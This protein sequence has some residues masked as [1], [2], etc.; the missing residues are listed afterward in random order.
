MS[1]NVPGNSVLA[2]G[3]LA[4]AAALAAYGLLLGWTG[5]AFI[6]LARAGLIAALV[7]WSYIMLR[8]YSVNARGSFEPIFSAEF[9]VLLVATVLLVLV[10]PRIR[11]DDSDFS[12][13]LAEGNG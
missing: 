8:V 3:W 5:L 1:A 10:R 6:R 11:S 2:L 12:K 9:L 7:P 4:G 13:N